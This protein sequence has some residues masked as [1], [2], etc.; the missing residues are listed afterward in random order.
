M[1]KTRVGI[2][3]AG[4]LGGNIGARLAHAG[5]EVTL[6]ARGETARAINE[7][8]VTLEMPGS[9][10]NARPRVCLTAKEAGPQDVV[11]ASVKAHS[12]KEISADLPALCGPGT[13]VVY[14]LNGIPWWYPYGAPD[15]G[16]TLPDLTFLDPDARLKSAPGLASAIGSVV[17]AGCAVVAPGVVRCATPMA[18]TVSIGE[19]DHTLSPRVRDIAALLESAGFKAPISKD[20]HNAA[21]TKLVGS[22]LASFI[23]CTLL[24]EPLSVFGRDRQLA[25]LSRDILRE[26]IAVAAAWGHT[27]PLEPEGAHDPAK[28]ANNHKPSMAHD[29][30]QGKPLEIDAVLRVVQLFA[31]AAKVPTQKLDAVMALLVHKATAA[32]LY[33]Q[34]DS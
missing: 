1:S 11:F 8:G 31:R 14:I 6:I 20:I 34:S 25:D 7:R 2:Y 9:T 16:R 27:L 3:G 32:G 23:L 21:W 5:H 12:L 18:G 10:L 4:A 13:P 29:F 24:G 26:G 22:N 19:P 28:L 17:Y 33:R 30:E 15:A